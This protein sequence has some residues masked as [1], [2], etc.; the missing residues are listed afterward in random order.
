[1]DLFEFALVFFDVDSTLVTIEGIEVLAEG[2][3]EVVEL[4]EAAM[5]GTLPIDQVYAR[6]L[7]I[8][9]PTRQAVERLGERYVASMLPDAAEVVGVLRRA[10]V[11]VHLVSAAIRQALLPFASALGLAE[12]AVH[13]V[14]LLFESDGSYRDFDRRSFLTRPGG[15]ELTILDVRARSKGKA[16]LVGDGMT[17]AEA[18]GAVD[19]FIGFGGVV[20]REAVRALAEVYIDEPQLSAILPHL[21]TRRP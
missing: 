21:M 9:R 12:R 10:R 2:S 1:M 8:V 3:R 18:R 16:A 19:L 20:E 15:K 4:T 14:P 11:D 17:D 6:R 5:N 13:A 7:D